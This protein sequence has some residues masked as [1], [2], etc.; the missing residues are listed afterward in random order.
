MKSTFGFIASDLRVPKAAGKVKFWLRPECD[1]AEVEPK[2][3]LVQ[4]L[5]SAGS[6]R[7]KEPFAQ[8]IQ[9]HRTSLG[10]G[11]E[12]LCFCSELVDQR[13]EARVFPQRIPDGIELENR[14]GDAVWS[15]E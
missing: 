8:R 4:Y 7:G 15:G 3:D 12:A 5:P 6:E 9:F 10:L 13:L 2:I 14:D 11:A 1:Q